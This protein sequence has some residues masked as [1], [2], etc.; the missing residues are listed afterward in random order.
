[1]LTLMHT[2]CRTYPALALGFMVAC[3]QVD[4]PSDVSVSPL[5]E[6]D[7]R[8][9]WATLRGETAT[10]EEVPL[11]P[12]T[13][14]PFSNALV[15]MR[16]VPAGVLPDADGCYCFSETDQRFAFGHAYTHVTRAL[17]TYNAHLAEL[18]V[19]PVTNVG[20]EI[21]MAEEGNPSLGST[22]ASLDE[23]IWFYVST[24]SPVV[25]TS[26]LIHELGHVIDMRV[27]SVDAPARGDSGV[28]LNLSE[29]IPTLV[30]A[31]ALNVERFAEYS[32]LD[33]SLDMRRELRYPDLLVTERE[34]F[35]RMIAAPRFAAANPAWIGMLEQALAD[36]ED[37]RYDGPDPYSNAALVVGPMLDAAKACGSDAARRLTL[38]AI[39]ALPHGADLGWFAQSLIEQ[40]PEHC[41]AGAAALKST[42]TNR[43]LLPE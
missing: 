27:R 43:G 5:T 24:A 13:D 16:N 22:Q 6:G 21:R 18:G 42:L 12:F 4:P 28:P 23:D 39:H 1:M 36:D 3:L 37:R 40:A 19:A 17:R 11:E 20:V 30:A 2:W 31:L 9:R 26:V 25:D 14:G 35:S 29:T 33:A 32:W 10:V 15:H 8:T 7:L 38:A 34:L 41:A